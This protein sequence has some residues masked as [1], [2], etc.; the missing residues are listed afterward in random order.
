[1]WFNL[2]GLPY[3]SWHHDELMRLKSFIGCLLYVTSALLCFHS[4]ILYYPKTGGIM[5]PITKEDVRTVQKNAD[6][7]DSQTT[8]PVVCIQKKA[9]HSCLIFDVEVE[10]KLSKGLGNPHRVHRPMNEYERVSGPFCIAELISQSA[11]LLYQS[12]H[13]E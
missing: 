6:L 2:Y 4:V 12:L 8:E 9:V 3:D 11:G 7:N 13:Q 5:S 1:M 10:F